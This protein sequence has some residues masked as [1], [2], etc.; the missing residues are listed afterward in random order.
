MKFKSQ[1]YTQVSGS[2]GG[3]T[4]SHNRG[5]MYTRAR[6]IPTNPNTIRQNAVRM[7]LA[8]MV[9]YWSTTLTAAQRAAWKVYADATPTTDALGDPLTLTGQ[10]MFLRQSILQEQNEITINQTAPTT[11]DFGVPVVSLA[12]I[13]VAAGVLTWTFGVGGA[14]ADDAGIKVFSIG[15]P[16]NAGRAFFKGPY[17]LSTIQSFSSGLTGGSLP[18]TLA[19]STDWL[20]DYQPVIGDNLP[21]RMRL[22]LDDGRLSAEFKQI[23]T[24]T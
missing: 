5:G 14:G 15:T 2:I 10:Q 7:A 4:Y 8:S 17:Q 6:S 20:A 21:V 16:L 11:N 24:V 9:A 23:I 22:L 12:S 1:V 19:T 3:I 13:V 18:Q